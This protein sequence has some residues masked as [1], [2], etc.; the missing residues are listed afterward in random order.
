M[1]REIEGFLMV[2]AARAEGRV[3]ARRFTERVPWLT[4]TQAEDVQRAYVEVHLGLRREL[5]REAV[6]RAGS[7]RGEYEERYRAMRARVIAG[8]WCVGVGV[9][10]V[11]G[12]V[13][14]M[15]MSAP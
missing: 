6:E 1:I 14:K 11:T 10:G 5:W 7:L 15:L 8:A 3:A 13:V 4:E 2:E 9:A 12:I